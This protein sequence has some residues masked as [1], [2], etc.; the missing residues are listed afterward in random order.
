MRPGFAARSGS[1][2]GPPLPGCVGGGRSVSASAFRPRS[3]TSGSGCGPL[4]LEREPTPDLLRE[5]RSVS[6]RNLPTAFRPNRAGRFNTGTCRTSI[7]RSPIARCGSSKRFASNSSVRSR[8]AQRRCSNEKA[9]WRRRNLRA[10][11]Y[12]TN[13]ELGS[14]SP[15]FFISSVAAVGESIPKSFRPS[16]PNVISNTPRSTRSHRPGGADHDPVSGLYP[17]PGLLPPPSPQPCSPK[18]R[19]LS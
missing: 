1:A 15:L 14:I 10:N 13:F 5:E 9:R 4:H 3:G 11:F 19:H 8:S 16:P 17:V 12:A 2:V 6:P 18:M 7:G